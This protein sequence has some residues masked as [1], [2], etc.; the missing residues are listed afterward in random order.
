MEVEKPAYC[1]FCAGYILKLLLEANELR[2]KRKK[3]YKDCLENKEK[4]TK[5]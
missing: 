3:D 5:R 1:E 2:K 4:N